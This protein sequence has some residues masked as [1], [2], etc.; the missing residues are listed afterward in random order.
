[1][2][3]GW[4]ECVLLH[5]P[6]RGKYYKVGYSRTRSQTR[7]GKHS[8][9]TRITVIETN[10]IDN[11]EFAKIIFIWYIIAMPGDHVEDSVVLLGNK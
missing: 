6:A 9:N 1:M 7:T 10:R 2:V 8:E 11:H 3:V 5:G 4:S